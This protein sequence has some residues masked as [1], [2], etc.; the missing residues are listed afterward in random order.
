MPTKNVMLLVATAIILT[1]C[2]GSNNTTNSFARTARLNCD[3]QGLEF[4][5]QKHRACMRKQWENKRAKDKRYSKVNNQALMKMGAAMS[6]CS[7]YGWGSAMGAASEGKCTPPPQQNLSNISQTNKIY[8]E[9]NN[10]IG[11]IR[12]GIIYDTYNNQVGRV[13]G[14]IIYNNNSYQIGRIQGSTIYWD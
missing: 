7:A 9:L 6:A 3:S 11:T 10:Y 4:G 1:G 8:D 12:D 2:L 13:R 5:S 14:G